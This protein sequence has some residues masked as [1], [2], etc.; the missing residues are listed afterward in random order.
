MKHA[1]VNTQN[2]L[3]RTQDFTDT[4]PALPEAKG[5]R[6]LEYVD[7]PQ[8]TFDAMTQRVE[9]TVTVDSKYTKGWQIVALDAA[10]ITAKQAEVKQREKD[11]AQADLAALDLK[12]IRSLREYIAAKPDAP[13]FIKQ[14][15]TDA[16]VLRGKLK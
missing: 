13:A 7:T 14:Y 11:K 8:P 6:W 4:P 10:A 12:S 9:P 1:L 16:A 3:Q 5:L 2:I 15:D